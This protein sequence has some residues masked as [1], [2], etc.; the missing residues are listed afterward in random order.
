MIVIGILYLVTSLAGL[1]PML[2]VDTVTIFSHSLILL[3]VQLHV[4]LFSL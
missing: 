3:G 1:A 4:L 2:T